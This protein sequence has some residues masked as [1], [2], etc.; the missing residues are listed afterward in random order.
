MRTRYRTVFSRVK[1]A[2]GI[3]AALVCTITGCGTSAPS[4]P[5]GCVADARRAERVA[6]RLSGIADAEVLRPDELLDRVCFGPGAGTLWPGPVLAL[7]MDTSDDEAAARLT[8]LAHHVRH[9]RGLVAH[10]P[11]SGPCGPLVEEALREEAQAH[12]VEMQVRASLGVNEPRRAFENERAILAMPR[13]GRVEAVLAFLRAHPD[14][15]GGYEPLGRD[16]AE[17]CERES[18]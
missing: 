3:A 15:G 9:G 8:H 13:A 6:E 11:L 5:S 4:L 18:R 7:P 10:A 17:R 1:R 12:V 14:G 2:L 16:Y